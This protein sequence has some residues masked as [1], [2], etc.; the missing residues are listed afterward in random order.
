MEKTGSGESRRDGEGRGGQEKRGE[1]RKMSVLPLRN[2]LKISPLVPLIITLSRD[3]VF[4]DVI[5]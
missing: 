1:K 3:Q 2:T 5:K 4:T